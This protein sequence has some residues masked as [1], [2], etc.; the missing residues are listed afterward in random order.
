MY[1]YNLTAPKAVESKLVE[2]CNDV[3]RHVYQIGLYEVLI[4]F[5]DQKVDYRHI[6]DRSRAT[7]AENSFPGLEVSDE[8]ISI[9]I[10][11][12]CNEIMSRMEPADLAHNLLQHDE[13]RETLIDALC[14]RWA[15]GPT[16]EDRRKVI[17]AIKD[18]VHCTALDKLC[19]AMAGME[20]RFNEHAFH[21]H[22]VNRVNDLLAAMECVDSQG[23]PLRLRHSDS[24]PELRVTGKA[25]NESR[26]FWR[27]EILKRFPIPDDAAASGK[28][29]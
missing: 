5:E 24:L 25:W 2:K 13:A 4:N 26:E 27:T 15:D 3:S 1:G 10:V 6:R 21:Y 7:R 9:P 12:L 16:D 11:D 23:E 18:A 22:E 19:N 29:E 14:H 20:H 8:A 28:E 17:T